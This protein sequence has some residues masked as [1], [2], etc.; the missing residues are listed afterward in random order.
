MG[1]SS[2]ADSPHDVNVGRSEQWISVLSG[3]ALA[4]YGLS[5]RTP[6]GAGL[7]LAGAGLLYRGG[8]G[9]CMTYQALGVST[10]RRHST[11]RA[12]AGPRG[13]KVVRAITIDRPLDEVYRFWRNFENLPRF[14]RHLESVRET[15]HGRSRWRARGPAGLRLSWDAEIINEVENQLIGWRSIEGDVVSAGSVSFRPAPGGRG[16]E[17]RV[18]LQYDPPGGKVAAAVAKLFGGEAS[19]QIQ[20]DLR[21][22]KQILEAGEAPTTEGQPRG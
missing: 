1:A 21:R 10:A 19:Q 5:R 4:L 11:R 18:N 2:R 15:G 17:I 7:A 3:V 20:E 9:H 22:L 14:M 16:T 12:L 6:G 8:T 13:I